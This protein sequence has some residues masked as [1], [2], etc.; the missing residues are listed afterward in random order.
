MP[1][2]FQANYQGGDGND[3]VL[4]D[5][6][7]PG[8]QLA[9]ISQPSTVTAGIGF[10]FTVAVEDAQGDIATSYTGSVTVALAVNPG[11]STLGGTVVVSVANGVASFSGLTLNN[12]GSGYILQANS[13]TLTGGTSSL[14]TVIPVAATFTDIA[15][16]LNLALGTNAKLSI[17]S[18]GSVY[19]LTLAS[20][21]LGRHR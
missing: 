19:R 14:I 4:T 13:G 7:G 20:G 2:S 21:V 16:S 15:P 3:L 5:I 11:G 17:V 1:Y 18:T 8:T 12:A 6:A 9:V 10:G